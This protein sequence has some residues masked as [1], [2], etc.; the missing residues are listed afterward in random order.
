MQRP[1]LHRVSL[2]DASLVMSQGLRKVEE[3]SNA[4]LSLDTIVRHSAP[5]VL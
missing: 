4:W 3:M 2:L 1:S 5:G